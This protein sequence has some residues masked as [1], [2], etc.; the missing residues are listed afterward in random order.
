MKLTEAV[1]A[2][3]C[4]GQSCCQCDCQTH[5][6]SE[7]CSIVCSHVVR[8]HVLHVAAGDAEAANDVRRLEA[9]VAMA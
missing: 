5:E 7:W 4:A 6:D 1:A 9:D 3:H 2:L 8:F